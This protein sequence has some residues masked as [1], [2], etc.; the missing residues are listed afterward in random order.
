[1][2]KEHNKKILRRISSE[3]E[4]RYL[5]EMMLRTRP[6]I[7][8]DGNRELVVEHHEGISEYSETRICIA[9]KAYEI[10]IEEYGLEYI[11]N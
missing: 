10:V 1:M 8:L 7:N 2:K 4:E 3:A 11:L 6:Q 5:S 9:A